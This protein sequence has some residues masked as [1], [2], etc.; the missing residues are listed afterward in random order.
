MIENVSTLLSLWSNYNLKFILVPEHQINLSISPHPVTLRDGLAM[1]GRI[2]VNTTIRE[3][4]EP[5]SPLDPI[6]PWPPPILPPESTRKGEEELSSKEIYGLIAVLGTYLAF[7]VYL[8]WALSPSSW[9]DTVG[10]TWYPSR[11]VYITI[12]TI[13]CDTD[14]RD[15]AVIVPSYLM[16]NVLLSYWSY[17]ALTPLL[18]P[19]FDSPDLIVGKSYL[20]SWSIG[21][22]A[23]HVQINTL[24][25]RQLHLSDITGNSPTPKPSRKLSICLSI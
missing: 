25:S 20:V 23:A 22:T 3:E 18:S 1:G 2:E 9:L 7:G 6:S 8:I 16:I 17:A 19:P 10:W 24:A 12:V 5:Q 14:G 21:G 13:K 11:S 4:V 15:W